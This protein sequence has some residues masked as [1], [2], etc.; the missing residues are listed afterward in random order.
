MSSNFPRYKVKTGRFIY[1]LGTKK[2]K[3]SKDKG[4]LSLFTV[5]LIVFRTKTTK[6]I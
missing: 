6:I 5:N 2:V 4:M 3:V 1:D